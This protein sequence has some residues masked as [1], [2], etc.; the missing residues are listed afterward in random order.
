MT[1]KVKIVENL[2]Y[3]GCEKHWQCENCGEAF[4]I[5]CYSKEQ[6]EKFVCRNDYKVGDKIIYNPECS[7]SEDGTPRYNIFKGTILEECTKSSSSGEPY[8]NVSVDDVI[9]DDSGNGLFYYL[10]RTHKSYTA[11]VKYLKK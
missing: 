2:L 9:H 1:H 7:H 6:L 4:P 11:S 8:Y 10:Q 5:H 3:H